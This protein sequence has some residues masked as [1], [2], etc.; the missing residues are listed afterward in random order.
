MYFYFQIVFQCQS[1]YSLDISD[2]VSVN[3]IE[4]VGVSFQYNF[5]EFFVTISKE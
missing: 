4:F 1:I 3:K 2:I 5:V